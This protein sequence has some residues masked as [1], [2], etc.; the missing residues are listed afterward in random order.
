VIVKSGDDCRQELLA[1]QLIR[2][3]SDIF[4]VCALE[5]TWYSKNIHCS[6][7][8]MPEAVLQND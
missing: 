1:I 3:F 6:L 8:W 7:C 2:A 5:R 4:R